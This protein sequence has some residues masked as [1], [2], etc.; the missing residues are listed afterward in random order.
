MK[1]ELSA[2]FG[3][4]ASID[5]D[6]HAAALG[7]WWGGAGARPTQ[8]AGVDYYRHRDW[9]G[10]Y[11]RWQAVDWAQPT[12]RRGGL[13]SGSQ[14]RGAG[15]VGDS[16]GRRGNRAA[17][18]AADRTRSQHNHRRRRPDGAREVFEAARRG[19]L[20]ACQVV[21]ETAFYIGLGIAAVIPFANP[22]IVILGGS[23]GTAFG[24]NPADDPQD[25]DTVGTA[26]L[27]A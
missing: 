13:V 17:G 14:R 1:G 22:Q 12:G 26:L 16:S 23:I 15:R 7:E 6:G 20:L 10:I 8:F 3:V 24:N 27:C 2:K 5:Y 18:A 25:R 21:E 9:C 11:R 19:D 4:P